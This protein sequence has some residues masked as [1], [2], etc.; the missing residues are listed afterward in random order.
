MR[1]RQTG[2]LIMALMVSIEL[3][4]PWLPPAAAGRA[5]TAR[6]LA[7]AATAAPVATAG[8]E[9][10]PAQ[11]S[12]RLRAASGATIRFTTQNGATIDGVPPRSS[13]IPYLV[14]YRNGEMTPPDQRT[15]IVELVDL[16]LPPAGVTATLSV[17]TEH[18]D[19]DTAGDEAPTIPAWHE[20]RRLPGT[21]AAVQPGVSMR[22]SHTFDDSVPAGGRTV[23]TPSD[24]FRLSVTVTSAAGPV[25]DYRQDHAFLMEEQ[26]MVLLP[27]VAEEAPGAAPDA[28]VV[29]YTNMVPFRKDARDPGTWVR[30]DDVS[31]Y[32]GSELLPAMVRAFRVQTDEWGFPWH[33]EWTGYRAPQ[34]RDR[35]SV[36]LTDGQE[37]FHDEAPSGGHSGISL[38]VNG[39]KKEYLTL[40]DALMSTFHHELFHN[41]QLSLFQHLGGRG[42]VD[43]A[44]DFVMEGTAVLAS[45]VA[46]PE[47]QFSRTWGLR[48]YMTDAVGFAGWDGVVD[49]DLNQSYTRMNGYHAAV[50]WR[51]LY[52]QCGGMSDGVE[53]PARGMAVIRQVLLALYES[54]LAAGGK[55]PDVVETM[56]GILGRAL[57]ASSCPFTTYAG[58]LEAFARALYG[59]G[60]EDGRCAEPGLPVGC[61][62]YDPHGVYRNPPVHTLI[63]SGTETVYGAQDQDKPAGIPSSYGID[64]IKVVLDSH[65]A[66]PAVA[67][68]L[69]AA[70]GGL[71]DL[72]VQVL[73]L[74][75]ARDGVVPRA[76]GAVL[77]GRTVRTTANPDGHVSLVVPEPD[78]A[79]VT[80]LGLVIVRTDTRESSDVN[81]AY[82]LVLRPASR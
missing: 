54:T 12:V 69:Y 20:T 73:P 7:P 4:A 19:P 57:A 15:L 9:A 61:G 42:R 64:L 62:L 75:D 16:A 23:A 32:V 29:Y 27:D 21:P 8:A 80:R 50:Y 45:S 67:V 14:L 82:T 31:D 72:T 41:Q 26:W 51:F 46:Q 43:A 71:A 49:G 22:F 38:N 56:P 81:G 58:S 1:K 60:L 59:L 13:D 48:R 39:R 2:K 53:N 65:A 77:A 10:Q 79:G 36:A 6:P 78:M 55:A 34:E 40:T 52:E 25:L 5:Q 33:K 11:P 30:R 76:A 35:L 18:V 68:D 66:G 37:W 47:V 44:W 28:L 3:I 74:L 24:Y 70:A 17:E 63:Y